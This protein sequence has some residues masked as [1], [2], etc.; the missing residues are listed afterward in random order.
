[1]ISHITFWSRFT[2]RQQEIKTGTVR[3]VSH[4]ILIDTIVATL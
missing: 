1:M 4:K 3:H 2:D